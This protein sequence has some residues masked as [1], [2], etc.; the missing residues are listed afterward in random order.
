VAHRK[1]NPSTIMQPPSYMMGVDS[2]PGLRW[3]HVAG[4]LGIRP[5]GTLSSDFAE[6][7]DQAFSNLVEVLKGANMG[8]EDVV[9]MTTYIL[10]RNNLPGFRVARDK[11]FGKEYCAST[12]LIVAGL[13]RA[14]YQIEVEC[15]AA[16]A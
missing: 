15:I 12:L 9:R 4:Q 10:D 11:H 8:V 7:A 13:A 6:Q 14:E 5:D 16:K 1:F 2:A 3:L